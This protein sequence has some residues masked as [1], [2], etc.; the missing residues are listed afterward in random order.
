MKG[1]G[2]RCEGVN[3]AKDGSKVRCLLDGVPVFV[4]GEFGRNPKVLC[5]MH[6][7]EA[8]NTGWKVKYQ[9]GGAEPNVADQKLGG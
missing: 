6:V 3:T 9:L 5:A 2:P 8:Q 7:L 1:R 4:I